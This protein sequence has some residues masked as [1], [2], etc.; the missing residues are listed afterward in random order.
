MIDFLP[1]ANLLEQEKCHQKQ[2]MKINKIFSLLRLCQDRF[3]CKFI[4]IFV[5]RDEYEHYTLLVTYTMFSYFLTPS[6]NENIL[7]YPLSFCFA[8]H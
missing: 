7:S 4:F 2:K 5:N 1:V 3:S 6:Q 8:K